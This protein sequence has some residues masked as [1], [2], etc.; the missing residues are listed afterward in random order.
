MKKEI[1]E[2]ECYRQMH[3]PI[4]KE[5]YDVGKFNHH[6]S[7]YLDPIG[8]SFPNRAKQAVD[9]FIIVE[10]C[11]QELKLARQLKSIADEIDYSKS[12]FDLADN[13]D[14]QG[15]KKLEENVYINAVKFLVNYSNYIFTKFQTIIQSPEMGLCP[16]GSIDI[17]W[18]TESCRL[19]VNIKERDGNIYGLF[20]GYTSVKK[21]DKIYKYPKEGAIDLTNID[22]LLSQW[23]LNLI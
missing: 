22:P 6:Y 4:H 11:G 8:F 19:L 10:I 21:D 5:T 14:E 15:A 3:N 18:V 12:L 2:I 23:M 9:K 7:D 17:S 1:S 16:D 13:W 20:Y